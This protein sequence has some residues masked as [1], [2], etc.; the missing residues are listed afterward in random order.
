MSE[1]KRCE[2]GT[3][4]DIDVDEDEVPCRYLSRGLSL[5]RRLLGFDGRLDFSDF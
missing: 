5:R 4:P 1:E 2:S 3:E